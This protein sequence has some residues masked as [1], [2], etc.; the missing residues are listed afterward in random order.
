MALLGVFRCY[1]HLAVAIMPLGGVLREHHRKRC[2]FSAALPKTG[3]R[4]VIIGAS[5]VSIDRAPLAGAQLIAV[6]ELSYLSN[7]E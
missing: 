4:N 2:Q 1:H 5:E 6:P 7:Q 3:Q